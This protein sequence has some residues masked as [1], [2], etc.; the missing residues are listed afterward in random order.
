M[1]FRS[2]SQLLLTAELPSDEAAEGFVLLS[3]EELLRAV[4]ALMFIRVPNHLLCME[5]PFPT[6]CGFCGEVQDCVG[7]C[8]VLQQQH[9]ATGREMGI[10]LGPV[11]ISV[12]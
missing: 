11:S 6:G 2:L 8:D 9:L 12:Y 3:F 7:C 1:G 10:F 5:L 4:H